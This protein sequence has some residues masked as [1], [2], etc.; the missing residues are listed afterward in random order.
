MV[1]N[2]CHGLLIIKALSCFPELFKPFG[3]LFYFVKLIIENCLISGVVRIYE[4]VWLQI[5]AQLFGFAIF[6]EFF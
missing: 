3:G 5:Y 2:S 6:F 4:T 1:N